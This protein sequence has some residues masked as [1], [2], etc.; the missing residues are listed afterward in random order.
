[1]LAY[2]ESQLPQF[3]LVLEDSTTKERYY[4]PNILC[5]PPSEEAIAEQDGLLA[6]CYDFQVDIT[7]PDGEITQLSSV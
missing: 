4:G 5:E 6:E 7:T 2:D 1:M 3:K